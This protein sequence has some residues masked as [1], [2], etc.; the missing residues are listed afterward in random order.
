[1]YNSIWEAQKNMCARCHWRDVDPNLCHMVEPPIK[2]P[3]TPDIKWTCTSFVPDSYW[4]R[5]PQEQKDRFNEDVRQ[6]S[7][8]YYNN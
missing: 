6:R 3:V 2:K 7:R 4:N 8:R 1:M 5:I